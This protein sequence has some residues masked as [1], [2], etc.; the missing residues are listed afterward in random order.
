MLE[1]EGK[2]WLFRGQSKDHGTLYP[3]IDRD[4]MDR[5]LRPERLA[6][7]RRSIETFRSAARFFVPGG[8]RLAMT[9]DIIALMVLRHYGAPTR[10]LDWT[11]S[12]FVAAYFAAYSLPGSDGEIWSFNEPLYEAEGAKQWTLWPET[13]DGGD[14]VSFNAHLTAFLVAEPPDWFICI[15]YPQGFPRQRSQ[16]GAY[17]MT[18]RFSQNHADHIARILKAPQYHHRFVIP[19]GLKQRVQRVLEAQGIWHGRPVP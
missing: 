9:D 3:S 19:A 14:G 6:L 4:P 18:A 15:F 13:T 17:S 11:G 2:R 5:L 10:L 7:E 1:L 8:E 12:P 16:A